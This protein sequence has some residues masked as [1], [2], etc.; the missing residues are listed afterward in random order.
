MKIYVHSPR[1]WMELYKLGLRV[2]G[3]F[4]GYTE[5][6]YLEE[7]WDDGDYSHL[8][9]IPNLLDEFDVH[10]EIT[11][12]WIHD[13][14]V[15]EGGWQQYLKVDDR[16]R[17]SDFFLFNDGTEDKEEEQRNALES[18][19]KVVKRVDQYFR[20]YELKYKESPART[21]RKEK[22]RLEDYHR[23]IKPVLLD[24]I[25]EN[26]LHQSSKDDKISILR[27][28]KGRASEY[29]LE[30]GFSNITTDEDKESVALPSVT[31][32]QINFIDK[33]TRDKWYMTKN[34]FYDSTIGNPPYQK[35]KNSDYYVEHIKNAAE[36]TKI[37]GRVVL[38]TPNKWI[39]PHSNASK[40]LFR[41]YQV[42]KLWVDV[43]EHF[44]GIGTQIGMFSANVSAVP[45]EG[46]VEVELADKSIIQW[47]PRE[48]VIPPKMP[49]SEGIDLFKEYRILK[50]EGKTLNFTRWSK[51]TIP[52]HENYVFVW[53][54]WKSFQG[55]PYFDAE[56]GHKNQYPNKIRDGSYILTDNPDAMCEYLRTTV[57]A[58]KLYNLFDGMNIYPFMWDYIP[59]A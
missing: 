10:D 56:V 34:R 57:Y 48:L 8:I 38:V 17:S 6:E 49:T 21:R 53:R 54:Q 35:G 44:K 30:K 45:H 9:E 7:R 12:H 15:N 28:A 18:I 31:K 59:D 40:T 46:L 51:K 5:K 16:A 42:Q 39:L 52:S 27:D 25:F 13:E 58:Q 37:G 14:L 4:V 24:F 36:I 50:D 47:D 41:Y 32:N 23:R 19:R 33:Q 11:D 20:E 1:E 2:F 55:V 3:C 26:C 22:R 29:L 43:N